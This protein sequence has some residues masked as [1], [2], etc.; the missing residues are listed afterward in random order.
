MDAS[1][2]ALFHFP[3]APVVFLALGFLAL[4]LHAAH[5]TMRWSQLPP[6]PDAEGFAAPFAGVS[7]GALIVAG[8]ANIPED[9]WAEVFVKKWYDSVF[10]FDPA[11]G[12]WRTTTFKLPRPLGYGVSATV[13][14][15]VIGIGGSDATQHYREVFALS[16]QSDRLVMDVLPALP[17]SCANACGAALGSTIYVA[18]G[19]ETP[20]STTALK[21]FWA[22]DLAESEPRWRELE[23]CPGPARM[24]AVAGAL[25]GSFFLFSGVAL[26]PGPDGK[27][28]R[29]YLRD[30]WRF[31]PDKGWTRLADLPRAAVAAPSPAAV[32]SESGLLIVSGDDGA[33]VTFAPV[34]KHPGF[35]R[36]ALAYDVRTDQWTIAGEIPVSRATVP[37]VRWQQRYVIPNGEVRPRLRTPEVWS[38][39]LP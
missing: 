2:T 18:G 36:T 17:N 13:G 20:T 37:T 12:R 25:E 15:R 30:A 16:W 19:L 38:L 35:P 11:K 23:P 24:H 33:H 27:P 22:L 4:S 14:D 39:E 1:R 8:G 28:A 6:I 3:A 31:T 9:K 21:T 26:A 10:L 7:G 32:F 5:P 34:E 29:E